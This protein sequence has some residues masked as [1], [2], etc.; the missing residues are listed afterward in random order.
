VFATNGNESKG[1]ATGNL[2]DPPNDNHTINGLT[3]DPK[4]SSAWNHG[5]AAGYECYDLNG[6]LISVGLTSVFLV[7][8][9]FAN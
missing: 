7:S 9:I 2:T 3:I 5:Y 1:N 4:H 8:K 6:Y